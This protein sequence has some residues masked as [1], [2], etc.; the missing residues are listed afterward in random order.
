MKFISKLFSVGIFL[1]VASVSMHS[2]A[3]DHAVNNTELMPALEANKGKVIYIDF[4]ASWC[5]P[6]RQSFPW[7]NKIQTQFDNNEFTVISINVDQEKSLATAFLK[8]TPANF[9]VIYDPQGL[10][11]KAFKLKGMPSSYLIDQEGRVVKSHIGFFLN[12]IP[13]Y[14]IEISQLIAKNS[15]KKNK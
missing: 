3:T 9:P 1:I 13:Q 5:A 15:S 6:C 14:E 11:A 4:W 8:E 7:M 2:F 12:R 10:A